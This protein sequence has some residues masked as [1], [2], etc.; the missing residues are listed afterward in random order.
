MSLI[1]LSEMTSVPSRFFGQIV[2]AIMP[3]GDSTK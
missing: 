3:Q 1:A 2:V